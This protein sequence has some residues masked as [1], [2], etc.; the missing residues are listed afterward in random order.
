MT[1]ITMQAT[2]GD[3]EVELSWQDGMVSGDPEAVAKLR[4]LAADYEGQSVITL[5]GVTHHNHL[6]DPYSAA[7]L[8]TDVLG[9]KAKVIEGGVPMLPEPPEGAVM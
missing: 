6:A 8:M 5:A 7:G 1:A 2:W 3:R 9:P 4:Q